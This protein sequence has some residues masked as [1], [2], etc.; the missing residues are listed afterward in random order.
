MKQDHL[1]RINRSAPSTTE[2]RDIEREMLEREALQ[3]VPA[4][5][6]YEL[7]DVADQV[8]ESVLRRIASKNELMEDI[9]A[10]LGSNDETTDTQVDL[11]ETPEQQPPELRRI[12]EYYGALPDGDLYEVCAEFLKEAEALGYTFDYGLDGMPYDLRSAGDSELA[13]RPAGPSMG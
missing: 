11:F 5:H 8:D 4:E 6:Y 12:T 9:L 13:S 3:A 1:S 7:L 10:D 2:P